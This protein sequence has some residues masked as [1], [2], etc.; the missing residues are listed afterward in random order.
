M[1]RGLRGLHGYEPESELIWPNPRF[2]F[3]TKS[4]WAKLLA[5]QEGW[6][7]TVCAIHYPRLRMFTIQNAIRLLLA[8]VFFVK[9]VRPVCRPLPIAP[10]RCFAAARQETVRARD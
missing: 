5:G 9:C 10:A 1:S 7:R 8:E 3:P 4:S 6:S 2:V